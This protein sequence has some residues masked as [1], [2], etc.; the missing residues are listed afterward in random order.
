MI[1]PPRAA[2]LGL[3]MLLT[4]LA[5]VAQAEPRPP[6]PFTAEYRLKAG[7]WPQATIEQRLE[8]QSDG[9]WSSLMTAS[10][11]IAS[12]REYGQFHLD[13]DG[14]RLIADDFQSRYRLFGFG[15]DYRFD[16]E[17]SK[18]LPDRQTA[19]IEI[20]RRLDDP[21]CQGERTPPC[22]VDYLDHRQ[23]TRSLEYRVVATP[24]IDT[25]LG[26]WPTVQVEAR[27]PHH[28]DRRFDFYVD[29]R[30]PGLMVKVDYYKSDA[31]DSQLWLTAFTPAAIDAPR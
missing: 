29:P 5:S 23:R 14:D 3:A 26:R 10:A 13:E 9:E 16:P 2:T 24:T 7:G 8:R 25:A 30:Y 22:R 27:D 6:Y 19:L 20:G 11:S 28:P 17:R 15:K 31:L 18:G 1:R 21:Q 4:G 12:G